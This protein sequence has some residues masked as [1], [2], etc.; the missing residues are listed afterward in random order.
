MRLPACRTPRGHGIAAVELDELLT[1]DQDTAG[2]VI[3]RP[4]EPARLTAPQASECD[5]LRVAQA[6]LVVGAVVRG[7]AAVDLTTEQTDAARTAIADELEQVT[8]PEPTP[9]RAAP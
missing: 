3:V 5:A 9:L 2:E 6:D 4:A 7:L 8:M 1:D